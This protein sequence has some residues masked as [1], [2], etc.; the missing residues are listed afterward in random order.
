M[1]YRNKRLTM[2]YA[3]MGSFVALSVILGL[4]YPGIPATAFLLTAIVAGLASFLLGRRWLAGSARPIVDERD[5]HNE[6][7]ATVLCYKATT[8]GCVAAGYSLNALA[9][10][11]SP[12]LVVGRTLMVVSMVLLLG[13]GAL[14]LYLDRRDR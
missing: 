1:D 2:L 12:A 8:F 9:P 7:R 6:A 4:A 10:S 5:E 11:G 3:A 14:A 13:R